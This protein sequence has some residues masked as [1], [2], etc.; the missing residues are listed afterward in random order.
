[1]KCGRV[2]LIGRPNAGKSTLLNHL[3]EV[4][5]AAVS[6]K[7]QTTR[8][9]MV[10]LLTNEEGQMVL[11]DTPGVHKPK[12]RMNEAMVREAVSTFREVDVLCLIA[13]A[14]VP[15]G[16]GDQHLLGLIE[17]IEVPRILALN[18]VDA[19]AK[20]S[21]L[22]LIERYAATGMFSEIVPISALEGD[23]VDSLVKVLWDALPE[24]EP[25]YDPELLTLQTERYLAAERVRE[26]VLQR[27]RDEL[28]FATTVLIDEWTQRE[29]GPL[30]VRASIVVERTGQRKIVIGEKGSVI[31]AIGSAARRDLE[32]LLGKPIYLDLHVRCVPGWRDR[33]AL[34]Q[35][36]E[37]ESRSVI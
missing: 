28:P 32:E 15:F 6:S 22:P 17:K 12:H 23:G 35:Q 7:P 29:E 10:G 27:T 11:F 4:P 3:V 33:P 26:K 30:Y 31:K 37:A 20:P 5:I 19:I 2:G 9:R 25:I 16:K 8:H 13:D 1:M 36:L 18:K 21:L 24:G 14:S 34:L